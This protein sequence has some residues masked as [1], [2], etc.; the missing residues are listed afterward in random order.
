[1]VQMTGPVSPATRYPAKVATTTT[2]PGVIMRVATAT[3]KLCAV[4]QW[5]GRTS[6]LSSGPPQSA[7]E[8]RRAT[9]DDEERDV[10]AMT[11]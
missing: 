10:R 9:C 1:M 8:A 2:G 3:R 11:L 6:P 5:P 7:A 4:S